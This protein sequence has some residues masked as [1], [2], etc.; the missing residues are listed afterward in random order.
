MCFANRG[1]RIQIK[2]NLLRDET[3]RLREQWIDESRVLFHG[4]GIRETQAKRVVVLCHDHW[5]GWKTL[6]EQL[7]PWWS[8][9]AATS[10]SINNFVAFHDH[11]LI[12]RNSA[13]KGT[14]NKTSI[15]VALHHTIMAH[16]P[17]LNVNESLSTLSHHVQ[18]QS[19]HHRYRRSTTPHH[20]PSKNCTTAPRY[21]TITQIPLHH[22]TVP[23]HTT[24]LTT[25]QNC[26]TTSDH[27]TIV[28]NDTTT[29]TPHNTT[30]RSQP[31]PSTSYNNHSAPTAHH[32]TTHMCVD[33]LSLVKYVRPWP[34]YLSLLCFQ[35]E[36]PEFCCQW[37]FSYGNTIL[38]TVMTL[39]T[40][41]AV[42]TVLA[43]ATVCSGDSSGAW[44]QWQLTVTVD[45]DRGQW[46][47]WQR[48]QLAGQWW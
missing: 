9:G 32:H 29:H 16:T 45:N 42:V 44:W 10:L 34:Q 26:T 25:T 36:T 18:A 21:Y 1:G 37:A 8:E 47:W 11:Q 12:L 40:V 20:T 27:H 41:M 6:W 14:A 31:N 38:A 3:C 28:N 2:R 48:W 22:N 33:T 39:M 23:P 17:L 43:V 15:K 19:S 13:N 30:P 7:P 4:L 35:H 24:A 5:T 46:Q